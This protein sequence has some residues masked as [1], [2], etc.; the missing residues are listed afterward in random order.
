LADGTK[1][2]GV[3]EFKA[4]L[5]TQR[6]RDFARNLTERI[7]AFALGR[8]VE[9]Y[10]EAFIRSTVDAMEKDGWKS[11]TLLRSV[12]A[13]QAFNQQSNSAAAGRE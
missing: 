2:D 8:E 10:D 4:Y 3:E 9:Y 6:G 11:R 1:L 5:V 13:S 12:L 7:F